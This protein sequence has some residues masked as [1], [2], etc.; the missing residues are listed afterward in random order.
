MT[1]TPQMAFFWDVTKSGMA[2][3]YQISDVFDVSILR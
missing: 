1:T 3:K 2:G